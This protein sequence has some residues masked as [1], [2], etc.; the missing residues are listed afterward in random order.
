MLNYNLLKSLSN[1][2]DLEKIDNLDLSN[3]N[4]NSIEL[5]LFNNL[6]MLTSLNL[7]YNNINKIVPGIFNNLPNLSILNFSNSGIE[8]IELGSFNNLV[9]IHTIDLNDN[10]LIAIEDDSF[11]NVPLLKELYLKRN[12]LTYT[13]NIIN[14]GIIMSLENNIIPGMEKNYNEFLIERIK[15]RFKNFNIC[16]DTVFEL[17]LQNAKISYFD[18]NNK[19][20]NINVINKYIINNT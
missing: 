6:P 2:I 4:I 10:L 18:D 13:P 19:I 15:T 14:P 3:K 9:S 17:I 11:I 12:N 8:Y 20:E 7:S 5:G 1:G 16:R